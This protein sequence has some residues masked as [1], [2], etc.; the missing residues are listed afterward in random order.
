MAKWGEGDPRWIVEERP[1]ATNVNNW[2][3]TEKNAS[4]W[5]KDKLTELL[6]HLQLEDNIGK[7][8]ITEI[9]S[10]EGEAVVNNRKAKLIFFYEWVIKLKWKGYLAGTS[11]EVEGSLEIPNLSEEHEPQSVDVNV[12]VKT[13]GKEAELLKEFMRTK[14]AEYIKNVL[15]TYT[16]S[17]KEEFSQGMI[18]PTKDQ[19]NSTAPSKPTAVVE[20]HEK[21]NRI[22]KPSKRSGVAIEVT[23]LTMTE[24]FKCTA[25]EFYNAMTIKEMVQAFTQGPAV[26]E[27]EKGG[28]FQLFDGNISGVFLELLPNKRIRQTWRSKAWPEAYCSEVCIDILQKEDCTD[29]KLTQTGVPKSDV[30]M[31]RN[32]WKNYYWQNMKKVFGFGAILI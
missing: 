20:K 15:G 22:E 24:S 13:S 11:E 18:L 17:L 21:N 10:C 28:R 3:W 1:D 30:E 16:S 32:G 26:L 6:L 12:A 5:S 14:G 23:T 9:T 4:Q 29:I 19:V 31:T 25:E 8:E 2:H 27:I 7:C